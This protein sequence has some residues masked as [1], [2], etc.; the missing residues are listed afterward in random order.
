MVATDMGSKHGIALHVLVFAA[1]LGAFGDALF[2][3]T[4]FGLNVLLWTVLLVVAGAMVVV[5][6][7]LKVNASASLPA[8]SAILFGAGFVLHDSPGMI[9]VN[10]LGLSTSL[11]LLATSLRGRPIFALSN[12]EATIAPVTHWAMAVADIFLLFIEDIEWK[13]FGSR[14]GVKKAAPILRGL[15]LMVPLLLVFGGLMASADAV[16]RQFVSQPWQIDPTE[17]F[18]HGALFLFF[19][20]LSIGLM[21]RG[22]IGEPVTFESASPQGEGSGGAVESTVVVGGLVGLFAMFVSIQFRYLFGNKQWVVETTGL[23]YADY[24]RQGFFELVAIAA[25][26]LPVLLLST[27]LARR[28]SPSLVKT[29]TALASTLVGL[30]ALVMASAFQ[31]M[32]L[33]IST[34]GLSELRFYTTAFMVWI[35]VVTAVYCLTALVGKPKQFGV[36]SLGAGLAVGLVLNACS[37]GRWISEHNLAVAKRTNGLDASY[38]RLLGGDAVPVLVKALP[39]LKGNERAAVV[40]Y[41]Q[42]WDTTAYDWRGFNVSRNEAQNWIRQHRSELTVAQ[43]R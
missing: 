7:K 6:S 27:N 32:S 24:A 21:R 22:L 25:L 9:L 26:A 42:N 20:G 28:G 16:F 34:S 43:N 41:L 35:A 14:S 40:D 11:A 36:L 5:K 39:E 18:A 19:A 3:Q 17:Y 30:L 8:L 4:A 1:G 10:V 38:L 23:S 2:Y 31:R 29:F 33:Y 37:P 13:A 12:L 15:V